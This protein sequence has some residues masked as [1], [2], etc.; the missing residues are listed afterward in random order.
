[1]HDLPT[2]RDVCG[3]P[4]QRGLVEL[5]RDQLQLIECELCALEVSP[6][7]ASLKVVE[8]CAEKLSAGSPTSATQ[9][10]SSS[11]RSLRQASVSGA[12][13][14]STTFRRTSASVLVSSVA[15]ASE[16]ASS[17]SAR[18]I[19]KSGSHWS[20]SALSASSRARRPRFGGS[21]SSIAL[22][23][24][25]SRS[26]ST[27]PNVL[28][29]PARLFASAALAASS[30][31]A[32][33]RR[34]APRRA[35]SHGM[36]HRR[37]GAAPH[38]ARSGPHNARRC[39]GRPSARQH[40]RTVSRPRPARGPQELADRREARSRPPWPCR[41]TRQPGASAARAPRG[42][43]PGPRRRGPRALRQHAGASAR[44]GWR[45]VP[46]TASG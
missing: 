30:A 40:R 26:A 8:V 33:P 14:A 31:S 16:I 11:T 21:S 12:R 39:R 36:R 10:T 42:A 17:A 32:R 24:A 13:I 44:G 34:S 22:S 46:H 28:E 6:L 29:T 5:V 3:E 27:S 2:G 45:R 4:L 7:D 37:S 38:R 15:R 20:S 35:A 23:I 18:R 41:P 1:M 19:P 9:P 43:H 25:A